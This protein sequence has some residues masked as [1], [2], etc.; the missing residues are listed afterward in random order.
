[1]TMKEKLDLLWK[2]LLLIVLVYGFAQIGRS[3]NPKMFPHDFKGG[4]EHSMM[5]M[6]ED[7]DMGDMKRVNVH[8]E[9]YD[10]GD[11][12]VVI[13]VNGKKVDPKDFDMSK[14]EDGDGHVMIKK[15]VKDGSP[16]ERKMKKIKRLP[17]K[18]Q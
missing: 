12:T 1:M 3:H 5:W 10:D 2:Y 17:S 18:D 8:V 15:I 4:M 14:F 11:S 7:C 9:K 13:M 16:G 6:D